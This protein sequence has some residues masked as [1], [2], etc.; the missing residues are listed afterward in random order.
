MLGS[1][2]FVLGDGGLG[3][4]RFLPPEVPRFLH[5]CETERC[6]G[7]VGH[8]PQSSLR[9]TSRWRATRPSRYTHDVRRRAIPSMSEFRGRRAAR[10]RP[11]VSA[12]RTERLQ[13]ERFVDADVPRPRRSHLPRRKSERDH[14]VIV[15]PTWCSHAHVFVFADRVFVGLELVDS[16]GP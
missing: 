2:A 15:L 9:A 5:C 4:P 13:P 8:K 7:H 14:D 16:L 11:R 6:R 12:R 3:R 1:H 10:F